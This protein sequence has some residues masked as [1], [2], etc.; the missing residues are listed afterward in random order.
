MNN[1]KLL[2]R[3][4]KA[5]RKEFSGWAEK[6]GRTH[7]SFVFLTGDL[8]FNALE[9]VRNTLKDRFVNVGVSEQN[10]VSMAA[11]LAQQGL[12]PICYSIAPFA[13]EAVESVANEMMKYQGP[14]YLRL[15]FGLAPKSLMPFDQYQPIQ[16]LRT[17]ERWT[18]IV[19]GPVVMNAL[20]ALDS[21]SVSADVFVVN[22]LP[23]SAPTPQ[24]EASIRKTGKVLVVEEHVSR[25]GLGEHLALLLCKRNLV[26]KHFSSLC[27]QGYPSGLYGNQAFHQTESNLDPQSILHHLSSV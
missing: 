5:M 11:A 4:P 22:E 16:Q 1:L 2:S 14:S 26:P 25:G 27:A 20:Q 12:S 15:G 6:Y 7:S 3:R 21:G 23:L 8:G 19:L 13:N 9:G 17:G 10:M 24:L 18:V